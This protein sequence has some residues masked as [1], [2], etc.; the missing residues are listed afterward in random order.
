MIKI[1]RPPCPN[2]RALTT[3]YKHPDNKDAI[4]GAS[5][6][7]CMYCECQ[8]THI[9]FG[10]IEHLRPKSKYPA[11]EFEWSNL[12]LCCQRCN[13]SKLDNFN[14]EKPYI[15][16]YDEEPKEHIDAVGAFL[17]AKTP[18]GGVTIKDIQLNR[19]Q[20]VEKRKEMMEIIVKLLESANA[21]PDAQKRAAIYDFAQSLAGE[22]KEI[23]FFVDSWVKNGLG[24]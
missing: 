10:D 12:G 1:N 20:L 4:V 23:S 14:E 17:S 3:N 21:I 2:P 15:N 9:S 24:L 13:T 19:P 18:R 22:D 11:L 5:H 7:K 8:A 6:G 16:P